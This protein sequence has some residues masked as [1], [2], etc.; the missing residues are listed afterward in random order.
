ML[1]FCA[2][3]GAPGAHFGLPR[4]SFGSLS[5][6]E[7]S[8]RLLGLLLAALGRSWGSPGAPLALLGPS[9]ASPG[10]PGLLLGASGGLPGTLKRPPKWLPGGPPGPTSIREP[11]WGTFIVIVG[12]FLGGAK[13][14]S[15]VKHVFLSQECAQNRG[16]AAK[17]TLKTQPNRRI[18]RFCDAKPC[19]L[20]YFSRPKITIFLCRDPRFFE[21]NG[22]KH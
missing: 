15:L 21:K 19:I 9:W 14:K 17:M 18:L 22:E 12:I 2:S 5:L 7:P 11:F 16:L 20:R 1:L 13:A 8:F 10:A 3:C 6:L 4:V